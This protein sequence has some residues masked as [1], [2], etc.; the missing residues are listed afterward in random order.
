[1]AE[2]ANRTVESTN[3]VESIYNDDGNDDESLPYRTSPKLN[4]AQLAVLV[5]YNVCGGPLGIEPAIRAGGNFYTICGFILLPF[6]WSLPEALV[7]AELGS[8][9]QCSSGGVIWV[10][11]AFGDV[12]GAIAG[13]FNWI[14]GATDNAIYPALFLAYLAG[15]TMSNF[16]RFFCTSAISILL[17]G[18]NYLGLELVGNASVV[19][20]VIAMSPFIAMTVIGVGQI[21]TSRWLQVPER[22]ED[23]GDFDN[24]SLAPGLL[25][26]FYHGVLIRPFVNNMFW[27]LNS[28]DAAASFAEEVVDV[29]TTYPRGIFLGWALCFILYLVPLLVAT[30]ATD[31][32]QKDWVDGH[33][34]TVAR[35]I[36]GEFLYHWTVFAV[37]ISNLA[38]FEAEMSADAY[39]L[40][41]MAERGYLPDIFKRRSKYGTPSAGILT[42]TLVIVIFSI[43]DFSQLVELLN[44]NYII[45][46]LLEFAAFVKLRI[47]HK[48]LDRP[49][50]IPIP[51]ALSFLVVLPPCLACVVVLAVSS[52]FTFIFIFLSFSLSL[53]VVCL[54]Q[55]LNKDAYQNVPD[56]VTGDDEVS[57]QMTAQFL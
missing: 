55:R 32:E 37:G 13:Y 14:S 27:N 18:F 40:M 44:A 57:V 29:N 42:G 10:K 24:S 28:F 49:Y 2:E 15:D 25:P 33:L 23:A 4:L 45:A 52:W 17:A 54:Q 43:A 31:Y 36:G 53:A 26:L 16:Q 35:D 5:F 11:T 48:D 3:H 34:A 46:L 22:D 56:A 21:D 39:Q 9:F 20:C 8:A 19:I 51:D 7:T 38:L 50:R 47:R 30:G 6:I 12:P 41:G 1:M